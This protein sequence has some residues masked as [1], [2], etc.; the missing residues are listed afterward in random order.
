MSDAPSQRT[1][2][3]VAIGDRYTLVNPVV[4]KRKDYTVAALSG[5]IVYLLRDG[6]RVEA[7]EIPELIRQ[8]PGRF[9]QVYPKWLTD[10][11][12]DRPHWIR[13]G[14]VHDR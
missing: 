12:S 4:G 5:G 1:A 6:A 3:A 7:S 11:P 8:R 14:E 9:A 10:P 2:S 13:R